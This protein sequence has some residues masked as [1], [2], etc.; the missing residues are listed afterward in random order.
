MGAYRGEVRYLGRSLCAQEVLRG[1]DG[2]QTLIVGRMNVYPDWTEAVQLLMGL[3]ERGIDE[4]TLCLAC[5]GAGTKCSGAP[6]RTGQS[7][8]YLTVFFHVGSF[9]EDGTVYVLDSLPGRLRVN[10]MA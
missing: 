6:L 9:A 3:H 5:I 4:A 7:G 2:A 1:L 10:R 8:H